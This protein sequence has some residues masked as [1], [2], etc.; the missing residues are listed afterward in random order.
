MSI[1][2]AEIR[3]QIKTNLHIYE[4]IIINLLLL[5]LSVNINSQI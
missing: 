2:E 3:F 1:S 4:N 5:M